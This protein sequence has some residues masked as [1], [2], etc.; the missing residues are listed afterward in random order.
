MQFFDMDVV[1][2]FGY[3]VYGRATLLVIDQRDSLEYGGGKQIAEIETSGA[4]RDEIKVEF[5]RLVLTFFVSVEILASD[6]L[7]DN[8]QLELNWQ[9]K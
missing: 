6:Q 5:D 7:L 2:A 3:C 4:P 9:V 8:L 1:L